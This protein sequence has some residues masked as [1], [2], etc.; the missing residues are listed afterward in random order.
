MNGSKHSPNLI[1]PNLIL[2][3]PRQ[4][5]VYVVSIHNNLDFM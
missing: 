5:M 1:G 3:T 2:S 4:T